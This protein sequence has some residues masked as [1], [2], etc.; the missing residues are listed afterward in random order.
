MFGSFLQ[1]CTAL[2]YALCLRPYEVNK[3]SKV[4]KQF[5]PGLLLQKH[6]STISGKNRKEGVKEGKIK[7]QNQ[8]KISPPSLESYPPRKLPLFKLKRSARQNI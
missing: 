2:H 4:N 5:S 3:Q 1:C 6:A 8:I 7:F